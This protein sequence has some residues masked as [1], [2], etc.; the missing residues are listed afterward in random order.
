MIQFYFCRVV[1]NAQIYLLWAQCTLMV[2]WN[3]KLR[4]EG[5]S[6]FSDLLDK[7]FKIR[8]V[9]DLYISLIKG[10]RKWMHSYSSMKTLQPLKAATKSTFSSLN[11][12]DTLFLYTSQVL[13]ELS[14]PHLGVTSF[15]LYRGHAFVFLSNVTSKE[16]TGFHSIRSGFYDDE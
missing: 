10:P 4:E 12:R 2:S 15:F 11:H 16:L 8:I 7:T 13:T 1:E 6:E 3:K 9:C 5:K 14:L